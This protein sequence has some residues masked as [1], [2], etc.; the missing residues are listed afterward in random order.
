MAASPRDR[1]TSV[2]RWGAGLFAT[3][4]TVALLSV[5]SPQPA[6]AAEGTRSASASTASA[7]SVSSADD[8]LARRYAP[9]I[10]LQQDEFYFPAAVEPFLANTHVEAHPD[11]GNPNQQ[12]LVTNQSLGC[13]SCTNPPFLAGQR[14]DPS[15]VP[16]YAEV[17]HRTD[18][19]LPTNITDINYWTFFPYNNGKRVCVGWFSRWGC[20]GGY[21]TFG[22]HVGDWEH[23]TV[24]FVDDMPNQISMGQHDGGQTFRYGSGG[25]ALA[26][27]QPVVY[28][29]QGSHAMYPDARRHTYRNLP[30]GDSLNDDT[31]AGTL[32]DTRQALKVFAWQPVGS[33][34]GEWA[35]LNYTGRWGNPKS[36]CFFSEAISGECVLDNGPEGPPRKSLFD[37]RIQPLDGEPGLVG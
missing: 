33:F 16:A 21:S 29:A 23:V 5:L 13:D 9:R 7:D 15:A 19:G 26:G 14:P 35:W 37:P 4:S 36:G 6:L 20:V 17:V 8:A 2:R 28:A 25:V 34:T 31:S 30:N 3:V 11:N 24:R 12:F 10:W 1:S 32:W 22:N 18:N 27:D